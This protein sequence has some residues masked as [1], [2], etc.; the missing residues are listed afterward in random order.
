MITNGG[1]KSK[2]WKQIHADVL[3]IEMHPV[4][5]HP[6][7][8]LGAAIIAAIGVD[9]LGDWADANRFVTLAPPVVPD[10]AHKLAYDDAYA[11]WRELGEVTTSVSHAI[12]RS[13]R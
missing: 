7:A 2:L 4:A 6:G 10:P 1:S 13:A 5:G 12:A 3:G 9:T 11:R 8:S